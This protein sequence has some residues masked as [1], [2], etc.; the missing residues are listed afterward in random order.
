MFFLLQITHT[1]AEQCLF[2]HLIRTAQLQ[3]YV[4]GLKS[5]KNM[6]GGHLCVHYT[7]LC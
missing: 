2:N 1:R 3:T 5:E 6:K 4:Q 7:T